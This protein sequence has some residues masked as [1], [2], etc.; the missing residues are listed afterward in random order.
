M[1]DYAAQYLEGME[2]GWS[3]SLDKLAEHLAKR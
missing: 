1:V 2:M 3:M